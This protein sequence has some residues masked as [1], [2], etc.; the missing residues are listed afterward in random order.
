VA[1][2]TYYMDE[3]F[4]GGN[5]QNVESSVSIRDGWPLEAA[6]LTACTPLSTHLNNYASDVDVLSCEFEAL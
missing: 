4:F 2:I 3:S 5:V 1:T 6:Q